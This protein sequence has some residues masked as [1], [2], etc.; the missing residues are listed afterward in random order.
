MCISL[1][2]DIC[3]SLFLLFYVGNVLAFVLCFVIFCPNDYLE[4]FNQATVKVATGQLGNS[5]IGQLDFPVV[6]L[7]FGLRL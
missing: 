2:T 6:Y 4:N 7:L 3:S 5:A 1:Y